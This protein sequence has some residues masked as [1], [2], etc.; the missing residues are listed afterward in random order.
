LYKVLSAY[1]DHLL[2]GFEISALVFF[3]NNI[4]GNHNNKVFSRCISNLILIVNED[5]SKSLQLDENLSIVI[6][7]HGF[8]IIINTKLEVINFLEA[9]FK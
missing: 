3:G 4:D 5:F 9:M 6:P 8:C 1:R 7:I 2:Q